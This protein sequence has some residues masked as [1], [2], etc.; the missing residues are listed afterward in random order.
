MGLRDK[1]L[2]LRSE[3]GATPSERI[4]SAVLGLRARAEALRRPAAAPSSPTPGIS[5]PARADLA[6]QPAESASASNVR[7][8]GLRA[9][10]E[11]LRQQAPPVQAKAASRATNDAASLAE[12]ALPGLPAAFHAAQGLRARSE[13]IRAEETGRGLRARA[14]ALRGDVAADAETRVARETSSATAPQAPSDRFADLLH[15]PRFDPPEVGSDAGVE[16]ETEAGAGAPTLEAPPLPLLT[17]LDDEDFTLVHAPLADR[18]GDDGADWDDAPHAEPWADDSAPETDSAGEAA[19]ADLDL[20]P[21][22]DW[23]YAGPSTAEQD[24]ALDAQRNAASE[25]IESVDDSDPFGEWEREALSEAESEAK[26]LEERGEIESRE[27][28]RAREQDLLFEGDEGLTTA[29]VENYIA[30]QRKIDHYLALFDITKEISHIDR[31]EDLWDSLVYAIMGQ[32]GAETVAIFS[33]TSRVQSGGIFYPVAHSGFDMPEGWAL[34]RGDEIYDRLSEEDGVKY[35]EE[36]LSS[37]KNPISPMERRILET[38]R[39]RVIVPL[40]NMNRMYGIA[41]LGGQLAG[42]DYTIDDLEFLT[43]LGEIAAVGADRAL[44]RQEYERDT[45]ELRRRNM[46]HGSMFSLARRAAQARSLDDIYDVMTERLRE[47]FHV[48]SF[49]LVLLNPREREYRIFAGNRI[50]PESIEKFRMGVNSDLI[51]MISNLTRIYD[52]SDFRTNPAINRCYTNDDIGLM[53]HY[54]IAPL[55]NMNWLAGFITIHKTSQPWTE[56]ERELMVTA[57]EILSSA[58]ANSIILSERESLFRDPFSPLEERL[59][60]ELKRAREFN[61]PVALLDLRIKNI[62]RILEMN[63]AEESA[64]FLAA[65]NRTIASFLFETD[66]MARV[67]QGRFALILP[68]RGREEAEVFVRKLKTEFRRLRLL[69]GSPVDAQFVHAAISYPRDAD[70]AGKMLSIFE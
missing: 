24:P 6:S 31:F 33:T 9:R 5:R 68:G 25:P 38:S 36:F 2:K 54:W 17:G 53:Q 49:S 51:A 10:A 20:P 29:P 43:L 40:K 15:D 30:S 56:F 11:A 4:G 64:D 19:P 13:A 37:V 62:R 48:E 41:I 44:S 46:I 7:I 52:L 12:N 22:P 3:D 69:P 70:E 42:D 21:L 18:A 1:A 50:S 66:F 23:E 63:R 32:V 57:A 61:A 39:A 59:K 28:T 45:E 34:K 16:A 60:Q 27:P 65:V 58:V 8:R 14:E 67:G 35:V 55:I 26:R 47:D